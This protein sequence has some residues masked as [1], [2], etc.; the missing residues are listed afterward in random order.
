MKTF[1]DLVRKEE[2]QLCGSGENVETSPEN[3][4]TREPRVVF[5]SIPRAGIALSGGGIRSATFSLGVLQALEAKGVLRHFD[6]LSTVSGGG[7]AGAYWTR[8][9]NPEAASPGLLFDS[10]DGSGAESPPIRHMR[11]YSH[12]LAPR[13]GLLNMDVWWPFAV[14]L[15]GLSLTLLAGCSLIL[16]VMSLWIWMVEAAFSPALMA[17]ATTVIIFLR[18]W[19]HYQRRRLPL[20][21]AAARTTLITALA[22]LRSG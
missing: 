1:T 8:R 18:E 9:K 13:M 20:N 14:V 19:T 16:L 12:F 4:H 7:Y 3:D 21:D 10:R 2:S 17:A 22:P 5:R 15:S 6:Y 11:E